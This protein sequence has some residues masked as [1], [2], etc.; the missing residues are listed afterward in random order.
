MF[1]LWFVYFV[2]HPVVV[3]ILG[4][5]IYRSE[6]YLKSLIPRKD[7]IQGFKV[8]LQDRESRFNGWYGYTP[9]LELT[10]NEWGTLFDSD[11]LSLSVKSSTYSQMGR[12]YLLTCKLSQRG[13]YVLSRH[14]ISMV[15]IAGFGTQLFASGNWIS[16]LVFS[17][18]VLV[19]CYAMRYLHFEICRRY[20]WDQV[21]RLAK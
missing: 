1:W 21:V 9:N 2:V 19:I 6:C 16:A 5:Y 18:E 13:D 20:Y 7:N 11:K 4:H 14:I 17:F 12:E 8:W 15:T 10:T 3:L